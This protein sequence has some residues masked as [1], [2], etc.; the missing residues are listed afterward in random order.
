MDDNRHRQQAPSGDPD[1]EP[2]GEHPP[3]HHHPHD[4]HDHEHGSGLFAAIRDLIRPHSH[5]AA[6]KIDTALETD[7]RGIRALKLSLVALLITGA[8]Q[9]VVV[10]A[11]GSV[12]LF[13]DTL[14]NFA[15]ALTA[16]G[17]SLA[18]SIMENSRTIRSSS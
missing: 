3:D 2:A 14:H 15:D 16:Q 5:D 7:A 1:H 18:P 11:T 8:L 12:A 4:D 10:L 6:S 9:L 17:T 13:S